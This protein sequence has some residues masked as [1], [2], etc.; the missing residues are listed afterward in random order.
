MMELILTGKRD[1]WD[2]FKFIGSNDV[3]ANR[4]LL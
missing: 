3:M 4:T 1:Y 2:C